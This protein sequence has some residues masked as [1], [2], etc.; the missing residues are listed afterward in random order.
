VLD[1]LGVS[2]NTRIGLMRVFACIRQYAV[3]EVSL[4]GCVRARR[5]VC[6]CV[7]VCVIYV[8]QGLL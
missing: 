4:M 7:C 2:G 1:Q 8:P 5:S 3:K 6:A